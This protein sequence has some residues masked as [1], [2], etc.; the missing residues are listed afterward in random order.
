VQEKSRLQGFCLELHDFYR[1]SLLRGDLILIAVCVHVNSVTLQQ[2]HILHCV[3]MR[4]I[5]IEEIL[6]TIN[7]T[8]RSQKLIRGSV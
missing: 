7:F 2:L 1:F 3:T 6:C 5:D 8:E 4:L